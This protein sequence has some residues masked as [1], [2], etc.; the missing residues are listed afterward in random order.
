METIHAD[1]KKQERDEIMKRF[2]VGNIWTLIC[3]DLM[4][5][6]IDFKTVNQVINFDFP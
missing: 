3:T 4:A 6:G 1:K 2:R 5:R